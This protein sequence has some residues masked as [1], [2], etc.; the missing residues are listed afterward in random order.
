MCEKRHPKKW[1]AQQSDFRQEEKKENM[2][3]SYLLKIA[4]KIE[5]ISLPDWLHFNCY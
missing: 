4:G 5:Q 1:N 2:N 3:Y